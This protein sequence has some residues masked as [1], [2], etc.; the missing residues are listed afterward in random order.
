MTGLPPTT[1]GVR[2]PGF[3][4]LAESKHWDPVT[5]GVV[6]ARLGRAPDIRFF[7]PAEEAAAGA[8]VTS[9]CASTLIRSRTGRRSRSCS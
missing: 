7:T 1:P 2:F 9:Y 4:V 5:T 6:L 8:L 3:D